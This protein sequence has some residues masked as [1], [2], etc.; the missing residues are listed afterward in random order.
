MMPP[1]SGMQAMAA[2]TLDGNPVD[3]VLRSFRVQDLA[4]AE[5][6]WALRLA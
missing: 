4:E 6:E 1:T 5:I 3:V 2:A